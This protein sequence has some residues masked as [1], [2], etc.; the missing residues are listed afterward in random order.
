MKTFE[1]SMILSRDEMRLI[2]GGSANCRTSATCSTGCAED[3]PSM[4][5]N[6]RRVCTLCC[7]AGAPGTP[8]EPPYTYED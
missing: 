8:P 6:G 2:R 4:G 3:S 1:D 5:D 7:I